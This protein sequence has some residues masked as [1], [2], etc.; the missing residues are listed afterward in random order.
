MAIA[1]LNFLFE[2]WRA[3]TY[4]YAIG[5]VGCSIASLFV[6]KEDPVFLLHTGKLSDA[7]RIIV[8]IGEYNG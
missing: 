5:I 7:K 6:L 1:G 3:V 8:E 2:D 4:T